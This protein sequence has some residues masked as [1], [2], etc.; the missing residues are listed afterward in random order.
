MASQRGFPFMLVLDSMRLSENKKIK[1]LISGGTNN[2]SI[3]ISCDDM[4]SSC[5][6]N[7]DLFNAVVGSAKQIFVFSH[8]SATSSNNWSMVIGEYERIDENISRTK[9][10]M[11]DGMG[12]WSMNIDNNMQKSRTVSTTKRRDYVVLSEKISSMQNNEFYMKSVL[13]KGTK[14][15][16][17]Y[18]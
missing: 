16:Y 7:Q 6:G 2:I 13:L 5:G 1:E 4:I 18:R 14:H 12:I 11:D 9:S 17:I 3:V 10:R 8:A 15:G